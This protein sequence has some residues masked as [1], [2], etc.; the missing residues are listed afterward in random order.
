[1][2]SFVQ[3]DTFTGVWRAIGKNMKQDASFTAGCKLLVAIIRQLSDWKVETLKCSVDV[4]IITISVILI[5][6]FRQIAQ[7]INVLIKRKV[8]KH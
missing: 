8:G 7:R 5:A 2:C 3:M 6:R 4:F 1:M